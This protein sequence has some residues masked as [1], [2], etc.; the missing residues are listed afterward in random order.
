MRFKRIFCFH[1]VHFEFIL[2]VM[3]F[4]WDTSKSDTNLTGR[5]FDFAFAASVLAG[6]T[7]EVVDAR[8]NYSEVR[9]QA[10]GATGGLTLVQ[11]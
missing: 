10:I 5:S 3:E 8:N 6:P 4:V 1:V 7:I 2:P 9:I 11:P